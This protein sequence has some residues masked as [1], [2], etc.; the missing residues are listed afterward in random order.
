MMPTGRD[1]PARKRGARA[2]AAAPGGSRLGIIFLTVFVDLVGFG[3]I[4]PILPYYA[5]RFGAQGLGFGAL[6]GSY[7]LMQF[8]ATALL[9]R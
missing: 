2:P 8:L 4:L 9:G 6:V 5:Q 7:S 1:S 3:I